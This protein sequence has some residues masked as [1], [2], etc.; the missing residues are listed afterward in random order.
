MLCLLLDTLTVDQPHGIQILA[1]H[2]DEHQVSF[3]GIPCY[4]WSLQEASCYVQQLQ[5][6]Q[7]K[8]GKCHRP[9]LSIIT[10]IL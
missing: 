1:E 9:N 5:K 10:L 7:R 8:M 2:A 6:R 3:R 4:H